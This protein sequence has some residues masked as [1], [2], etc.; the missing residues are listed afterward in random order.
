MLPGAQDQLADQRIKA[1]KKRRIT[2][3]RKMTF[4]AFNLYYSAPEHGGYSAD[5]IKQKWAQ[6]TSSKPPVDTLG[7]VSGVGGHPRYRIPLEDMDDSLSELEDVKQKVH[8]LATKWGSHIA[9]DI[10]EFLMGRLAL[11]DDADESMLPPEF[12]SDTEPQEKA[13]AATTPSQP[14]TCT[15][16]SPATPTLNTGEDVQSHQSEAP[17]APVVVPKRGVKWNKGKAVSDASTKWSAALIDLKKEIEKTIAAQLA[18]N[19]AE[20]KLEAGARIVYKASRD[21]N[22][23]QYKIFICWNG[24]GWDCNGKMIDFDL[25]LSDESH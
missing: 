22:I 7:V 20:N 6:E 5:A 9:D 25:I 3:R 21:F 14:S 12:L 13:S 11:Q 10:A 2:Q 24:E 15:G 23:A 4:F 19:A 16:A 8:T 18:L 17:A 1:H